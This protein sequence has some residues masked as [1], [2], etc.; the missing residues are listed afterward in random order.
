MQKP[1]IL[2]IHGGMTFKNQKDYFSFLKNRKV[3][4]ESYNNWSDNFLDKKLG[5]KFQIVRPRMPL[6]ENAHYDHWKIHF[7]KYLPLLGK[8]F[9]LMGE[10]LG[11]I[12]LAKYLSENKLKNKAAKIFIICAPFDNTLEGE[13]L[14]GGFKLGKDLSLVEK[15]TK[16]LYFFFSED[17]DVVPVI[18]AEKYRKHFSND[19]IFIFKNKNG[20]FRVEEFPEIVRFVN[21]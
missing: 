21:K 6:K 3:S 18:H 2:Y 20:H 11:G 17:D 4:L 19:K 13:D 7:E 1:K 16:E 5:K 8:N 14:V 10:S 15:N 9:V 12:F